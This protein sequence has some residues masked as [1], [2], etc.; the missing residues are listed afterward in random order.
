M[1][2]SG[3]TFFPNC[4]TKGT[5]V[6][7]EAPPYSSAVTRDGR[8]RK[9]VNSGGNEEADSFSVLYSWTMSLITES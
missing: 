9:E 7:A 8:M 5:I 4:R 1:Y 6:A 3:E 2:S